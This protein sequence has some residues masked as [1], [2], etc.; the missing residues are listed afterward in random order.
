M[1]GYEYDFKKFK[2]AIDVINRNKCFFN[3]SHELSEVLD[4]A[5]RS[6]EQFE[7][8]LAYYDARGTKETSCDTVYNEIYFAM[9]KVSE[10][11]DWDLVKHGK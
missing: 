9:K 11:N 1:D 3:Q 5:I 7:K 8:L 6:F 10:G 4:M 2:D